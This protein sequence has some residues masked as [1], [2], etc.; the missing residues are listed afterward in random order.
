MSRID[1]ILDFW[2][3]SPSHEDYGAPRAIWFQQ[4]LEFDGEIRDRFSLD[5]ARALEGELEGWL[6]SPRGTLAYVVVVDQFPRN[7]FRGQAKAFSGDAQGR[8]AT[9]LA[10]ARGFDRE[11]AP[12]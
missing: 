2:F 9:R 10:I 3:L 11:L 5:V 7:L 1:E 12:F 8:D 4:D 6:L